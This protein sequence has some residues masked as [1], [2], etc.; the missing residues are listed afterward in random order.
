M[1]HVHRNL[2][3]NPDWEGSFY[4][5]LAEYGEW[6]EAE[7]WLL[8]TELTQLARSLGAFREISKEIAHKLFKIY[9]RVLGLISAHFDPNDLYVIEGIESSR[10]FA[11]KERLDSA[12]SGVFLGEI[13]PE[14]SFTLKNPLL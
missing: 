5:R 2:P 8:H 3:G 7:F 9:A 6:D 10:L 11:F 13:P 12:F 1:V 14:S 4:E